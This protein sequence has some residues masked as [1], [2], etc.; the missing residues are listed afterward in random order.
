MKRGFTMV[1]LMVV[2]VTLPIVAASIG[3]FYLEGRVSGA[4]IEHQVA[5]TR[6]L[7]IAH[8]IIARDL[9]N[10]T[11]VSGDKTVSVEGDN[12]VVF[13]V[14]D[15]GLTRTAEGRTR[16][17]SRYVDRIEV[18]SDDQRGFAV[19]LSSEHRL[20]PKRHV[21]MTRKNYVAR[22]R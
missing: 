19:T 4:R 7:S 20:L 5:A 6:S 15:K 1:E 13:A 17:L 22:R 12:T 8:E 16:V 2:I 21:R 10:A 18:V 14:S 3:L 9:R 11:A